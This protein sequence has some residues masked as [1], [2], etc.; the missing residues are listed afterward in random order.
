[1]ARIFISYSRQDQLFVRR[2]A[3][4]LESLGADIWLDVD[5]IPVGMKWSTAIQEGLDSTEVMIVVVSPYSMS[6]KNVEDEWQYFQDHK[7]PIVLVLL[8]P[9]R[10][11]FQLSRIQYIDFHTK[12]YDDALRML[13]SHL[14]EI[15]AALNPIPANFVSSANAKSSILRPGPAPLAPPPS[16]VIMPRSAI[17]LMGAL[18][19]TLIVGSGFVITRLSTPTPIP[20]PT[21]VALVIKATSTSTATA[22]QSPT[23]SP[24]HTPS[25]TPT[26]TSSATLTPTE[27]STSTSSPTATE[28]PIPTKVPGAVRYDDKGVA[29][30]WVPDG[31]FI[32]GSDPAKD[33]TAK[34][35]EQPAH[36]V[37]FSKGFWIDQIEVTNR[38][39]QTF[40]LAG[41]YTNQTYWSDAGWKWLQST[42]QIGPRLFKNVQTGPNYPQVGMTWYEAEAYAKWRGGR[43]PTEA[44]WEYAARGPQSLIYPWGNEYLSGQGNLAKVANDTTSAGLFKNGASWVN[45]FDL[46]GNVW[47]WTADWYDS[48]TYTASK[49]T[50]PI[51]PPTGTEKTQRGGSFSS[52]ATLGRAAYR[53]SG[54]PISATTA[55]GFRI[56]TPSP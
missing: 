35:D 15:G 5:D 49:A 13:H 33:K 3:T 7:K 56:I 36:E 12:L 41:G 31:C 52:G 44:E 38:N 29:Q 26:A 37:C 32:M 18:L 11:H 22:T 20:S 23:S 14:G 53:T 10:M 24:T 16:H 4:D 1:M 43:L 34:P 47:E 55:T 42:G 40:V 54:S 19:V 46:T 50:D 51:G 6:S 27:T 28:T 39:Y 9:S 25:A 45:A 17:L 2:L 21:S 48:N 30:V 8:E